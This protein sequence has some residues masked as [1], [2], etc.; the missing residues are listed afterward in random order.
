MVQNTTPTFSQLIYPYIYLSSKIAIFECSVLRTDLFPRWYFPSIFYRSPISL[1]NVAIKE[2]FD[3]P[4]FPWTSN[5]SRRNLSRP[6]RVNHVIRTPWLT[7]MF[8]LDILF[9][10]QNCA[11]FFLSCLFGLFFPP[12]FSSISFRM[13]IIYRYFVYLK[14]IYLYLSSIYN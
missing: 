10:L 13:F 11:W 6:I 2:C 7:L 3:L 8:Y 1:N 14:S 12:S 4:R 5:K 9:Y